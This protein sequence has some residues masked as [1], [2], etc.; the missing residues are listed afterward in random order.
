MLTVSRLPLS[1][2]DS[3]KRERTY[4]T[5]YLLSEASTTGYYIMDICDGSYKKV[6]STVSGFVSLS[7]VHFAEI[8]DQGST[9]HNFAA[10]EKLNDLEERKL[11]QSDAC[12]VLHASLQQTTTTT[13]QGV[14][15][16]T[17]LYLIDRPS[18]LVLQIAVI[19]IPSIDNA[20]VS[21][22][23]RLI[24]KVSDS[25]PFTLSGRAIGMG[26]N[27]ATNELAVIGENK[28]V[29]LYSTSA[30]TLTP[31]STCSPIVVTSLPRLLDYQNTVVFLIHK[32]LGVLS[33][34]KDYDSAPR[35]TVYDVAGRSG[36]PMNIGLVGRLDGDTSGI[37]V[38]TND[39]RLNARI[40]HPIV[41]T[42]TTENDETLQDD[43]IN[44]VEHA[45]S[46]VYFD[47]DV[48]KDTVLSQSVASVTP[49][50]TS[51]TASVNPY[52]APNENC[53]T[54]QQLKQ[55][56]YIL[57]LLQGKNNY[58]LEDGV[59]N[60]AKF[61]E[62]FGQPLVFNRYNTEFNVKEASIKVIQRYQDPQYNPSNRANLGWVIQV[63]V[64]I[65]E[66][67]HKQIRRLAKRAGYITVG[68][69]R[70]SMCG[71]LLTLESVPK[72]GQCRWLGKEEKL[73]LYKGFQLI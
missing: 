42:E 49:V 12:L 4:N 25:A 46:D 26:H 19:L 37:M 33:S 9:I 69:E 59:F 31:N 44:G 65:N 1:C 73:A 55:K 18:Q 35:G 5:M 6:V 10:V 43:A 54:Y 41:G 34:A 38:F 64:N 72:I 47:T 30:N 21:I 29:H 52:C 11:L 16:L 22:W 62:E 51:A 60:T 71:G 67:K 70:T 58:C 3:S 39:G 28:H 61:E 40:L 48:A 32:P 57:T 36:F 14:P 23:E 45:L 68:L 27:S 20:E 2:E 50:I 56:E 53:T 15:Q 17:T 63:S 13:T 8:V 66:G 24:L 7:A